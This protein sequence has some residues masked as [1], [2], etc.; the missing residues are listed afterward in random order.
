MEKFR[1]KYKLNKDEII[2]YYQFMIKRIKNF[3][4]IAFWIRLSIPILLLATLL[5]F[6][7]YPYF[8][9]DLAASA[10]LFLWLSIGQEWVIRQFLYL[11]VSDDFLKE[12]GVN[13]GENIELI[14]DDMVHLNKKE[15]PMD[16]INVIPLTK[17]LLFTYDANSSFILPIRIIGGNEEAGDLYR[18][19]LTKQKN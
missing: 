14:F 9:I 17:N 3:R 4:R 2:E 1:Y 10:L 5:I 11:R 16:S 19:I 12:L 6:E 15:I 7:L 18:F 13:E 8:Y